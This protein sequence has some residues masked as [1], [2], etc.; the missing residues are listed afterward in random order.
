MSG[1]VVSIRPGAWNVRP[2]GAALVRIDAQVKLGH[3]LRGLTAENLAL[4]HDSRTGEFVIL[5]MPGVSV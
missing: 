3:L 1:K 5:P 4:R 2:S